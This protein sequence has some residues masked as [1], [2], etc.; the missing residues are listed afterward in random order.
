M[1]L[2]GA[3]ETQ[4]RFTFSTTQGCF[5]LLDD[6]SGP[7]TGEAWTPEAQERR[8]ASARGSLGVGTVDRLA[9][10]AVTVVVRP[11]EPSL[12]GLERWAFVAEGSIEVPSGRLRV[13]AGSGGERSQGHVDL[14]PAHYR[15]R[16]ACDRGG[17]RAVVPGGTETYRVD[18]WPGSALAPRV[19]H[20]PHGSR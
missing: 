6:A 5:V 19:L 1:R 20:S 4:R 16:I 8:L 13:A 2:L 11:H 12:E 17:D 7:L 9:Q 14:A 15:A 18:L 3:Q 10:V